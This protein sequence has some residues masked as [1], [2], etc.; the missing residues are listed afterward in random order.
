VGT[1]QVQ[2]SMG[3]AEVVQGDCTE[4]CRVAEAQ[5]CRRGAE[6][7]MRCWC[8]GAGGGAQVGAGAEVVWRGCRGAAEVVQSYCAEGLCRVVAGVQRCRC[9]S[10]CRCRSAEVV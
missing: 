9:R 6:L 4:G 1:E 10:S 5:R 2:Q 3:G 7:Q 8:I